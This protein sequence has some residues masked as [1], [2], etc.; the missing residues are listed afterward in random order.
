M[1]K[2]FARYESL[3]G[4]AEERLSVLLQTVRDGKLVSA[5]SSHELSQALSELR[6]EHLQIF[7]ALREKLPEDECP[8][9]AA[10]MCELR[11]EWESSAARRLEA[12]RAVLDDILRLVSDEEKYMLALAPLRDEA[13]RLRDGLEEPA[14]GI[15]DLSHFTLVLE[16]VHGNP[17]DDAQL[18]ERIEDGLDLYPHRLVSGLLNKKYR[19]ASLEHEESD[20]GG[21]ADTLRSAPENAG[22]TDSEADAP[23]TDHADGADGLNADDALEVG[24]ECQRG[25]DH[26]MQAASDGASPATASAGESFTESKA[27]RSADDVDGCVTA[28]AQR[29]ESPTSESTQ[30][31]ANEAESD[32]KGEEIET[33]NPVHAIPAPKLPSEQKLMQLIREVDGMLFY[34]IDRL[35]F[36][37]LEDKEAALYEFGGDKSPSDDDR[38]FMNA[39]LDKL[40]SKGYIATY[41]Y[42]GREILCCTQ[43]L[44]ECL[45]KPSLVAKIKA[46]SHIKYIRL[47]HK[48]AVQDMPLADFIDKLGKSD[49]HLRIWHALRVCNGLRYM[50]RFCHWNHSTG[51]FTIEIKQ[52]NGEAIRL[53]NV[54]ADE[55]AG[56]ALAED[57]G[58]ICASDVLPEMAG[59][60]DSCHYCICGRNAYRWDGEHWQALLPE[61]DADTAQADTDS[62]GDEADT[63]GG[64]VSGGVTAADLPVTPSM[65]EVE[66]QQPDNKTPSQAESAQTAEVPVPDEPEPISADE[67][68]LNGEVSPEIAPE[69]LPDATDG[70][71]APDA[72][73]AERKVSVEAVAPGDGSATQVS[74]AEPSASAPAA[75]ENASVPSDELSEDRSAHGAANDDEVQE[76][77]VPNAAELARRLLDEAEAGS[78]PGDED[79]ALLIRRL[80]E[81]GECSR[82]IDH[83]HDQVV[84]AI[85]LARL[86]KGASKYPRCAE[87]YR[88]LNAAVPLFRKDA[89][90]TG[91][92]LSDIFAPERDCE[93]VAKLCACIHAMLF[94]V[95]AY[96][97][98]LKWLCE[99]AFQNYE[100]YFPELGLLK[101][102]YHRAL[103]SLETVPTGFSV[104]NLTAITDSR[105]RQERLKFL[106][107]EAKRLQS[108]PQIKIMMNGVPELL[109]LCFGTRTDIFTA[110]EIVA[111]NDTS[112]REFVDMVVREHSNESGGIDTDGLEELLD[113]LWLDAAKK[114]SSRR[115]GIKYDARRHVL[116]AWIERLNVLRAWLDETDNTIAPNIDE[117][118]ATRME[119]LKE[120]N[121]IRGSAEVQCA[122]LQ[123]HVIRA[124][125][126]IILARLM[127]QGERGRDFSTM[128]RSGTMVM[129]DDEPVIFDELNEIRFAEPW[130]MMLRHICCDEYDLRTVY[131]QIREAPADSELCDNYNQ[132]C[133]IGVL[134]GA[135]ARDYEPGNKVLEDVAKTADISTRHFQEH[136]EISYAYDRI[137]ERDRERLALLIDAEDSEFRRFFYEH[138]AFGGWRAFLN[139]LR[140]QIRDISRQ[141]ALSMRISLEK[142][143]K[144][145]KPEENDCLLKEAAR[146]ID[147]EQNFAVAEDYINR[148]QNGERA[149]PFELD[150]NAANH[151]EKFTSKK[152]FDKLYNFCRSIKGSSIYKNGADF[153]E[154]YH[155]EGWTKHHYEDA[156]KFLSKWPVDKRS[157]NAQAILD[158]FKLLGLDAVSATKKTLNDKV[159]C[160][161][162]VKRSEKNLPDYR[163]PIAMFGTQMKDT[164]EVICLFGTYLPYQLVNEACAF[165][166]TDTFIVLLD[167]ALSLD[168]RRKMAEYIF[169]QKNTGQA[170]FL[171][172]DRVLALYLALLPGNERLS[173]MLQC[174]LPYTICQP[175]SE[176][177]GGTADEMFFGRSSE[178]ASIRQMGGATVV[179]GGRQ[180]GKTALLE[181]AQH[182]DHNPAR[183][184]F[185]VMRSISNCES[186]NDFVMIMT[187]ACNEAFNAIGF[188]VPACESIQ[189]FTAQLGR[190]IDQ[191]KIASLRLFMDEADKFLDAISVDHY[192]QIEPLVDLMRAHSGRFKFVFAGLHN[193][194]RA[195]KA[196]SENGVFGQLGRPLCIKPLT[197]MD[198]KNLLV[199]PL[200]YLGFKVTN[201][202]HIDTILI[203][204][205]YYPGIIQYFGHELVQ[206][207]ISKYAL[208]YDAMRGNP[209]FDLQADQLASIM[210][211][212]NMND[213]IKERLRLTLEM[214]HGRYYMLARCIGVLLHMNEDDYELNTS[215]FDVSDIREVAQTYDIHC[216]TSLTEAETVALLDEMEEM[217][218][219]NRPDPDKHRYLLRRRSFIDVIGPTPDGLIHDIEINN[220]EGGAINE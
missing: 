7:Q 149:L 202:S 151:F 38:S 164:L 83:M 108:L 64:Q 136:L 95:R 100:Q 203:N 115:M 19:L 17:L 112:N 158:F 127:N 193:V 168:D 160:E 76:P 9:A 45:N 63:A 31:E 97:Y 74:E 153:V 57:E 34:I 215:G 176:G 105:T 39:A 29:D 103:R 4:Q 91:E 56:C 32:T 20:D 156:E 163:H 62:A 189:Q 116:S 214:D 194:Y 161:L 61:D 102:V 87:L 122:P 50:F 125:V 13:Q 52:E 118:R 165:H 142:E 139:A 197:P 128:L 54:R 220:V 5:D 204:S 42:Q 14:D 23:E 94:P 109:D 92:V 183:R 22:V 219:L 71:K 28:T 180:L 114:Y 187:G 205:N 120:L 88:Q 10:S 67:E 73:T 59:V 138:R 177:Y 174:T 24:T 171:V 117:L 140:T 60:T 26:T 78:D 184:E 69:T 181:R 207:L 47:P 107:E 66:L 119:L 12:S 82:E 6:E 132:L 126:D 172:I 195:K 81:E 186:E 198:A 135:D 1:E 65:E 16:A 84:E 148:F 80:L 199:R 93:P 58:A 70:V 185:V 216:L 77:D 201:D 43:Q 8:S 124:S 144:E 113:R 179:Y 85:V 18:R 209:P 68:S 170:S 90:L 208:Y 131:R 89:V 141:K 166:L 169:T 175:F 211:S 200:H 35:T 213:S 155:P 182:L 143:M 147:Q 48:V 173:A 129:Q 130:R 98:T 40:E 110:L 137:S 11:H 36:L 206:M 75:P 46:T 162:K 3:R 121:E 27:G 53:R 49:T 154:K 218:I 25:M 99:D 104:A 212:R 41:A 178:L 190:L 191:G 111:G 217:G 196:T 152:V 33:I 146:L 30:T 72:D 167:S 44:A 134:I 101:G 157:V 2:M 15:A 86:L 159:C 133:A 188:S 210:N 79:M 150:D 37:G 123:A 192:R 145:L 96:D 51:Y 106:R 55:F 21:H